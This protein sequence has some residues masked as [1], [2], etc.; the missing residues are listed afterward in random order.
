MYTHTNTKNLLLKEVL[1]SFAVVTKQRKEV[2]GHVELKLSCSAVTEMIGQDHLTETQG[3]TELTV[4]AHSC[5]R[6]NTTREQADQLCMC[7][8]CFPAPF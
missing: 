3:H 2:S 6:T 4:P 1:R 8:F 5:L 7:V